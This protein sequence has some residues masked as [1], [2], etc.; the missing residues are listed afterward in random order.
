MYTAQAKIYAVCLTII[1]VYFIFCIATGR[2]LDV[3]VPKGILIFS[4]F[5]SLYYILVTLAFTEK[6]IARDVAD[7]VRPFIYL[8]IFMFGY[9]AAGNVAIEKVY[10]FLAIIFLFE[11]FFNLLIFFPGGEDLVKIYRPQ[12]GGINFIRFSGTF[13]FSYTYVFFCIFFGV[14][15]LFLY[16]YRRVRIYLVGFVLATFA[17]FMSGSRAGLVAYL[18]IVMLLV[19]SRH[20]P[21]KGKRSIAYITLL[22]VAT[23]IL[24]LPL[25]ADSDF[26]VQSFEYSMRLID[27]GKDDP[28]AR[29]RLAEF[30]VALDVLTESPL[31]GLGSNKEFFNEVLGFH[32][33]SLYSYQFAKW[34]MVGFGIYLFH[35]V[36]IYRASGRLLRDGAEEVVRSMGAAAMVACVAIFLLGFAISNTDSYIGPFWFYFFVGVVFRADRDLSIRKLSAQKSIT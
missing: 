5:C 19:F 28:S 26:F 9:N 4:L 25:F 2:G 6:V 10:L 31:F 35:V 8:Y 3:V 20:T 36:C 23:F 34:G 29:R 18:L 30:G 16:S 7:F 14:W 12:A 27:E 13:G 32:L 22:A 21:N 33:E 1:S 15:S 17:I 11:F 24:M